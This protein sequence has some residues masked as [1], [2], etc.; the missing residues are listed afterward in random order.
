MS[1]IAHSTNARI[2]IIS[3]QNVAHDTRIIVNDF[4]DDIILVFKCGDIN[5]KPKTDPSNH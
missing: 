5:D 3:Q 1:K 2:A 4:L